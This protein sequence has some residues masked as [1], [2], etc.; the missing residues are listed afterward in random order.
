MQT[1]FAERLF[2]LELNELL[3]RTTDDRGGERRRRE[4]PLYLAPR[5]SPMITREIET[6]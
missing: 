4:D 3:N 6:P 1:E 2:K 5:R